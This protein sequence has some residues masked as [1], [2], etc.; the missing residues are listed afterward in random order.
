MI[1]FIHI[2]TGILALLAATAVVPAAQYKH[3]LLTNLA[4]TSIG[5]TLLASMSGLALVFTGSSVLRVCGE[6][7]A[8]VAISTMSTKYALRKQKEILQYERS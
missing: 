7:V 4:F 6:A 3:R 1:L 8:L 2:A 5:A